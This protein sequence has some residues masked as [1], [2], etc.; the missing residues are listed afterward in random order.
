MTEGFG[1]RIFNQTALG[2]TEAGDECPLCRNGTVE[3]VSEVVGRKPRANPSDLQLIRNRET[4]CMGECGNTAPTH[5]SIP[6]GPGYTLGR[7]ETTA[8]PLAGVS[9]ETLDGKG[10]TVADLLT[11]RNLV[12]AFEEHLKQESHRL[13]VPVETLCPCSGDEVNAARELLYRLDPLMTV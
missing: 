8:H 3:I 6:A 7:D 1:E 4:K 5:P 9:V 2:R 11:V 12:V 10:F 13:D